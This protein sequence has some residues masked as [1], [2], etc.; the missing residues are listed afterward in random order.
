[1]KLGDSLAALNAILNGL[2]FILL[3]SGWRAIRAKKIQI[4]RKLMG[5]AFAISI[6]FLISY[7][8]RLYLTGT[9]RY[10]GTGAMRTLYLCILLTH[11]LLAVTVPF[12]AGRTIYLALK[13]RIEKH[14]KI[15][16]ITL[17][18]WMYVSATGVVIYLMLY[19]KL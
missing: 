10:P 16:R 19:R 9:H 4:H 13:G 15:A 6:L 1:M 11:T 7:L 2:A 3:F 17:P 8:T 12:L 5:S 18:I 14:R